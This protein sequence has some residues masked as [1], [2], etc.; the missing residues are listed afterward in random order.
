MQDLSAKLYRAGGA[1]HLGTAWLCSRRY[2]LTAA[3]CVESPAAPSGPGAAFSLVFRSGVLDAKVKWLDHDLDAALL[4]ITGGAT[5]SVHAS[6]N[7]ILLDDAADASKEEKPS[8]RAYGFP[9]AKND[10]MYVD[11]VIVSFH[12]NVGKHPAIQLNSNQ[13]SSERVKGFDP[14]TQTETEVSVLTG[15]SGAA[16]THG[17]AVIGVVIWNPV[18]FGGQVIYAVPVGEI[19][20]ACPELAEVIAEQRANYSRRVRARWAR[21]EEK[22][23]AA[24]SVEE[25]EVRPSYVASPLQSSW[26]TFVSRVPWHE[27][28]G[29]Q[30]GRVAARCEGAD[31]LKQVA[32]LVRRIDCRAKYNDIL[33]GLGKLFEQDVLNKLHNLITRLEQ[34]RDEASGDPE[35]DAERVRELG[36]VIDA[37][38]D[39]RGELRSLRAK[40]KEPLFSRCFLVTGEVG[41]GKTH[42]VASL[43][44][45]DGESE[46]PSAEPSG[47]RPFLLLPLVAP[48][49][50]EPLE[51]LIL[52]GV[53]SATGGM[54]W[55]SLAE[56]SRFL[57]TLRPDA[58]SAP[59]RLVVALD[60]LEKWLRVKPQ[61]HKELTDFVKEQTDLPNLFWVFTLQRTSLDKVAG[62][63]FWAQYSFVGDPSDS[64]PDHQRRRAQ[65]PAAEPTEPNVG[66]WL[67]LDELN[68]KS[69]LGLE[70]IRAAQNEDEEGGASVPLEG[71]EEARQL[72]DK[73][74]I[75]RHLS[76]PFIAWVLL[77]VRHLLS[78]N[79]LNL[80]FIEFIRLFSEKRLAALELDPAVLPR[81]RLDY[82]IG[83]LARLLFESPDQSLPHTELV[84]R[85]RKFAEGVSELQERA[86]ASAG[87]ETL[88]AGNLLKKPEMVGDSDF[89]SQPERVGIAFEP[90]WEYHMAGQLLLAAASGAAPAGLVQLDRAREGVCE[91]L[92]LLLDERKVVRM[93]EEAAALIRQL[94]D[95][96]LSQPQGRS[97]FVWF[98]GPKATA[99]TQRLLV[100]EARKH[101]L[102]KQLESPHALLAFVTFVGDALP[103]EMNAP[104]RLE[105]LRPYYQKI[106][107]ASLGPY[108]NFILRRMFEDVGGLEELLAAMELLTGCE[109]AGNGYAAAALSVKKLEEVCDGSEAE[110]LDLVLRYLQ[111]I[112]GKP[113]ERYVPPDLRRE[114][115]P[116]FYRECVLREFCGRVVERLGVGAYDLLSGKNW[117]R[118]ESL[119]I[120]FPLWLE[121]QQQLNLALGYWYRSNHS[122]PGR[123][124]YEDLI[125]KLVNDG[126]Q[127]RKTAFFLIRHTV[128][129]QGRKGVRVSEKFHPMLRTIYKDPRMKKTRDTY[130]PLFE[131]NLG[132]APPEK[133]AGTEP[134]EKFR[135]PLP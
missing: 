98:A 132:V 84:E 50:D 21:Y 42:F 66:G 32:A 105:L 100:E 36:R 114:G 91:F 33:Y 93:Q 10:G 76:N 30:L 96:A 77:D 24:V 58:T 56:V 112:S 44:A 16:V 134:G 28:V 31:E 59:V 74:A 11:G 75:V 57:E 115:T 15:L 51:K 109:A 64:R 90:F 3:H 125:K 40:I 107:R 121:M 88:V 85:V 67:L 4:E 128:P 101:D 126:G 123:A 2:A 41:S 13:Y 122:A 48:H 113:L 110:M 8:W 20:R 130:H 131:V 26:E 49:R 94:L 65:T 60:G 46:D 43:L 47:G 117:Y 37:A 89:V 106:G 111:A 22:I 95:F 81:E 72:D 119:G 52:E 103:G 69:R 102:S 118:P 63:K 34:E 54:S 86:V 116:Y 12:G 104:S 23:K 14:E 25:L 133:D 92:L 39:A 135:H 70:L 99:D 27:E 73:A 6:V 61:F 108:F 127:N 62:E 53:G 45:G 7:E 83:L 79:I 35:A 5:E 1:T 29:L 9:L 71:L 87:V 129:T 97:A 68:R 38:Y 19:A 80:N 78:G 55:G 120:P 82:L 124:E 17:A 18:K